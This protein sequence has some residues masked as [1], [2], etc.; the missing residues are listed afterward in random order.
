LKK[1][2]NVA[3][4]LVDFAFPAHSLLTGEII[5]NA[6]TIEKEHWDKLNFHFGSQCHI[7]G[8]PLSDI[9]GHEDICAHCI[10]EPPYFDHARAPILY[11][12]NSKPL[13]LSLKHH[14]R[15]DG[16]KTFASLMKECIIDHEIDL[17]LPVPAHRIRLLERGYNQSAWL[18][19]AISKI[20]KI[21]WHHLT[22]VRIKNTKSQN[23]LSLSG[24]NRNVRAAFSVVKDIKGKKICL[25]DDVYTTGATANECAKA[26]KKAGAKSVFVLTLLRVGRPKTIEEFEAEILNVNV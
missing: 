8:T 20:T 11:D 10:S 21:R 12:E 6:G 22:L 1:L 2:G 19:A 18:A 15:K 4:R 23:G 7:C 5:D 3:S 26:L 17:L 24:R 9:H 14:G 13:V 16:I 25:I